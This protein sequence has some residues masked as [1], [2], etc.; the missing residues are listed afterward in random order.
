VS[1]GAA[2]QIASAPE[3]DAPTDNDLVAAVRRGD[4]TAF[5][6]LYARYQRRVHAYVLGMVKDHGRAEDVTQEVF[7]SAY[8]RM[9]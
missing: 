8:R 2:L 7:I 1:G 9:R 6:E 3:R 4:E 5:T